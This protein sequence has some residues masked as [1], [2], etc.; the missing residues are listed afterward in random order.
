MYITVQDTLECD[1]TRKTAVQWRQASRAL[2]VSSESARL[3]R[4]GSPVLFWKTIFL[5]EFYKSKSA[6]FKTSSTV[7]KRQAFQF[8]LY[9]NVV[10][11][12]CSKLSPVLKLRKRPY[13]SC[14]LHQFKHPTTIPFKN[15]VYVSVQDVQKTM[16]VLWLNQDRC[17]LTLDVLCHVHRYQPIINRHS[18]LVKQMKI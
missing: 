12:V 16:V 9:I 6:I 11:F 18:R 1:M 4:R 7:S 5:A 3:A 8:Q 15:T 13:P 17:L 2:S 10:A 14:T